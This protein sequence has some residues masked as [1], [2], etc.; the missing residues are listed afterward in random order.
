MERLFDERNGHP[1][2]GMYA[3]S[4]ARRIVPVFAA[5]NN[6]VPSSTNEYEHISA[7]WRIK[8]LP[9]WPRRANRA[10]QKCQNQCGMLIHATYVASYDRRKR[11]G[12]VQRVPVV[13][14]WLGGHAI[15][16]GK[17]NVDGNII[18]AKAL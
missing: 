17:H 4:V 16:L 18:L 12:V 14:A 15:A 7:S 10:L 1:A 13:R 2:R 11:R 5:F 9:F 3:V 8:Y 6:K